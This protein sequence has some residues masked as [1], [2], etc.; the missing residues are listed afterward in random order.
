[1]TDRPRFDAE[2][3]TSSYSPPPDNRPRWA[4]EQ[5]WVPPQP[6]TP[7]HWIEPTWNQGL[8]APLAPPAPARPRRG[9]T[10][11]TL[12]FISLLS[13]G[14]ASGGTY[15]LLL[16]TGHLDAPAAPLS[17]PAGQ[18]ATQTPVAQN[19]TITEQSAVTRP[20]RP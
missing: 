1:M 5:G 3:T 17:Q 19:V 11:V 18:T 9:R 14:L 8:Q 6:Q 13:A 15:Y 4:V 12:L 16:A 20:R 10:L 2:E 7:Q